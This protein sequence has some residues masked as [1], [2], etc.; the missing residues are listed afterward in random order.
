MHDVLGLDAL[1][2]EL[3]EN[4]TARRFLDVTHRPADRGAAAEPHD[5]DRGIERIAAADLVKMGGILFGTAPRNAA[6][7]ERQ[8]AHRNS[9]AQDPRRDFRR[10]FLKVHAGIRHAGSAVCRNLT[11]ELMDWFIGR[12][13]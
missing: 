5:S 9:D 11:P 13:P 6:D 2:R 8:V 12:F 7:A 3:F 1:M 10:L 4:E